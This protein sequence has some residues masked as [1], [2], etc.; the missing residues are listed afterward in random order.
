MGILNRV[1]SADDAVRRHFA[2]RAFADRARQIEALEGDLRQRM[3]SQQPDIGSVSASIYDRLRGQD[4]VT[5]DGIANRLREGNDLE[6]LYRQAAYA[7]RP[8]FWVRLNDMMSDT[9]AGARSGQGVVYTGIGGGATLGLTAAGQGLMALM[10]Y[11][12]QGQKSEIKR[13]QEL[14]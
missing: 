2:E 13:D 12:T 8:G 10:D 7:E 14:A 9:S 11:M 4:G 3:S 1:R 5:L 6:G